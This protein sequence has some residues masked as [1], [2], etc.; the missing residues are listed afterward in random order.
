MISATL[1]PPNQVVGSGRERDLLVKGDIL[2]QKSVELVTRS[3]FA[4]ARSRR[5]IAASVRR[6]DG[7]DHSPRSRV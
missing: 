5:S 1:H 2:S 4:I 6:L 3:R 7:F